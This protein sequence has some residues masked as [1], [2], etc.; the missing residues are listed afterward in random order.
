M[1][2]ASSLAIRDWLTPAIL[3]S[4]DC[5]KPSCLRSFG[6]VFECGKHGLLLVGLMVDILFGIN[7]AKMHITP[8][9]DELVNKQNQRST[10]K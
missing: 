6:Y 2:P 3:A 1:V 8:L 10:K 9:S 5:F 4:S 7:L